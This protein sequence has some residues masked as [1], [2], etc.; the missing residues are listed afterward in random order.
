MKTNKELYKDLLNSYYGEAETIEDMINAVQPH[1]HTMAKECFD[2]FY[3]D[4]LEKA[5]PKLEV[6]LEPKK[7]PRVVRDLKTKPTLL[8]DLEDAE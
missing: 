5:N 2:V 1:I 6:K 4:L 7:T 8:S 3:N